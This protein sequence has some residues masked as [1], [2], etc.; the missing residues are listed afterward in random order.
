MMKTSRTVRATALS[1][2]LPA[3]RLAQLHRVA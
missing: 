1:A 2:A 3:C